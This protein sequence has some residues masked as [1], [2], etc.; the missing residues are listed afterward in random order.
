MTLSSD[1]ANAA[2]AGMRAS[3]ARLAKAANCPPERH[4]AFALLMGAFVTLPA[5][6]NGVAIALE[7]VLGCCIAAIVV[8]DRWRTGMFINGYRAGRTRPL[9][10]TLLAVMLVFLT[11]SFWLARDLLIGWAPFALG[12]LA[13][14]ISYLFSVQWKKI[15]RQELG[16]NS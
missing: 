13:T 7:V 9:T 8:W 12:V 3:Q 14:A 4:L 2:L 6:S 15:F 16:V 11:L 1:E 10:F 5:F